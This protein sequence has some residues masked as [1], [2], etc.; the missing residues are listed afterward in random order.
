MNVRSLS[1]ENETR[2]EFTQKHLRGGAPALGALAR[3]ERGE[4]R[5]ARGAPALPGEAALRALPAPEPPARRPR[6]QGARTRV[7]R[8]D[9]PRFEAVK[10]VWGG[11][12]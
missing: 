1:H 6:L 12:W 7:E 4:P 11:G 10:V 9:G 5:V 8:V 3:A 2:P